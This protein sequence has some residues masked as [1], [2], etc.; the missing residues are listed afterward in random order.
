[1]TPTPPRWFKSSYSGNDDADCL[2]AAISPTPRLTLLVRDSKDR[3]GARLAFT[4]AA[5][6]EFLAF[7]AGR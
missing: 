3:D 6:S 1:M 5:W 4:R 2:E 7:T